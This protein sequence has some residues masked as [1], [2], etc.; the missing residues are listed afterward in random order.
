MTALRLPFAIALAA[1]AL[2][3]P[4]AA[5]AAPGD[6]RVQVESRDTTLLDGGGGATA[7][8]SAQRSLTPCTWSYFGDPRSI[9]YRDW[10]FT[11]CISPDGRVK[12]DEYNLGTGQKRLL[13]LFRGLE[14]DDHN[15][16]SLV[17]FKKK[18]YAFA[19]EH[20]GYV[21]PLDRNPRMQYRVSKQNYGAGTAW[22]PT[23]TISLGSG[24]G[25]GYTYPN[26]VVS[27]GRLYLFMRG[28][29]WYPYYTSTK[30]GKHWTSPKTMVLGPPAAGR[31]VRPY[32]K[33]VAAPDGSILMTFSDGHPGSY[34]N[35]LWYMRFKNGR[36]YK[37]DGSRIG[38]SSDL[39]FRLQQL[40][41]VQ[42]YS[43]KKGRPWPM[44]I[45]FGSD[46][47]PSIVYSSR[48][49]DDDVFRYARFNGTKW[50]TRFISD[51]GGSL[52]GYRNGGI[53]FNH[54]RP[55]LGRAHAA[56]RRRPGDR[57]AAHV[58]PGP[59]LAVV[60]AD[61]ELEGAQLPPGVPPRA[62]RPRPARRGLRVGLGVELPQLPHGDQDEHQPFAAG[63]AGP[64]PDADAEP[65]ADADPDA[66]AGAHPDPDAAGRRH[67]G[68]LGRRLGDAQQQLLELLAL[69]VVEDGEGARVLGV[70]DRGHV[71][72]HAPALRGQVDRLDPAVAV[73]APAL[74]QAEPLEVVEHADHRALVD[75]QPAPERA[76]RH[77][78]LGVDHHQHGGVT[79]ADAVRG[80]RALEPLGRVLGD[81]REQI[82]G[83]VRERRR[84]RRGDRGG[85]HTRDPDRI[86][87][88][89]S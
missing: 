60:A 77:R 33:Y 32:A 48:V 22:G 52:F 63:A 34:K 76:L 14:S 12:L 69:G 61:A 79:A 43:P 4:A 50:V 17:F 71:G 2:V 54:A 27:N 30:D 66:A 40:D 70:C 58:R 73:A 25:L 8:A 13:T 23:R 68:A 64:H 45:A 28:P 88:R 9:A 56:D 39:P 53:T 87:R 6:V 51:A 21:Y 19:S 84:E 18:L 47:V 11:G 37:A 86:A 82:P 20:S 7:R 67:A 36:F 10:I 85:R 49:G 35:N 83:P 15:N 55:E 46:G 5:S 62:D 3:V 57:A 80:D 29:C 31:N 89:T 42:S 74:R 78:P 81:E 41:K 44:D 16:P 59:D 72:E 24:C 65:G 1:L 75:P 26:P 38:R